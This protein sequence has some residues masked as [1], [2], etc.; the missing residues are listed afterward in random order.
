MSKFS[1]KFISAGYSHYVRNQ[2]IS[3][4]ILSAKFINDHQYSFSIREAV[5]ILNQGLK[6][7]L[8]IKLICFE[9]LLDDLIIN[10]HQIINKNIF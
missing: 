4:Y 9:N 2:E 10:D 7:I 3:F 1:N 6:F 8:T 5:E